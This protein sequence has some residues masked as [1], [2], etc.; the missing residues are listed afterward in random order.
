MTRKNFPLIYVFC[1]FWYLNSG[2]IVLISKCYTYYP[3]KPLLKYSQV[4]TLCLTPLLSCSFLIDG[5]SD[6]GVDTL[7]DSCAF[8]FRLPPSLPLPPSY[9]D[10]GG[11]VSAVYFHTS[12]LLFLYAGSTALYMEPNNFLWILKSWENTQNN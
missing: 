6:S 9:L 2:Q 1:T 3:H 12:E 5:R 7:I 11:K 4:Y 10:Q 8:R